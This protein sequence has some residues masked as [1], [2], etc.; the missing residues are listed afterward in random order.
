MIEVEIEAVDDAYT[1]FC[2]AMNFTEDSVGSIVEFVMFAGY[3]L[4]DP[5]NV[6]N[7]NSDNTVRAS[8]DIVYKIGL[9][10]GPHS[11][12]IMKMYKAR[13]YSFS[14]IVKANTLKPFYAMTFWVSLFTIVLQRM[15]LAW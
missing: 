5:F 15:R 8:E 4:M 7:Y 6:G 10:N 3:E 2:T 11:N 13:R 1:A 9:L 14:G 12:S